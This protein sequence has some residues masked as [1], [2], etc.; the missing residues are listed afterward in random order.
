VATS[1]RPAKAKG[2]DA[3]NV[4]SDHSVARSVAVTPDNVQDVS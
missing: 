3:V 2:Y 1:P 4:N